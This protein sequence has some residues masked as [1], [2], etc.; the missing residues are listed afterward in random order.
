MEINDNNNNKIIFEKKTNDINLIKNRIKE[1][2][3]LY[4]PITYIYKNN[5]ISPRNPDSRFK[6]N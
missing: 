4:P 1:F 3:I 5:K 2:N 6:E